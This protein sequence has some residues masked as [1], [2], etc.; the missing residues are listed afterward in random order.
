[1]WMV[2]SPEWFDV[3]VTGNMFGDIITDL[4]AMTQGGM[5][6][7]AGGNINPKGRFDVRADRRLCAEVHRQ[8][9]D[10]SA[11]RDLLRSD[12]ARAR[13]RDQGGCHDRDGCEVRHG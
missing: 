10:Q 1:M 12:A 6:L 5:G 2:K 8:E 11:S 3:L 13:G 4:G 7:A 9:R